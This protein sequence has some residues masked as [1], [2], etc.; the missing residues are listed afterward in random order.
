M[1]KDHLIAL[2]S[3]C[4]DDY[5]TVSDIPKQGEKSL[6]RFIENKVGGMIGNAAAVYAAYGHPT[7]MYDFM[8]FD[9]SNQ[10]L[11]EDLKQ[12][13]VNTDKIAFDATYP[14]SKCLIMLKGGERI[15]FVMDHTHVVHRLSV[16]QFEF[17]HEASYLYTTLSDFI[18]VENYATVFTQAKQHGLQIIF[19]VERASVQPIADLSSLLDFADILFINEQADDL[20]RE[21]LGDYIQT[22][23]Q[24]ALI[25]LTQAER[26]SMIYN[27]H[28]SL[29][30]EAYPVV[31]VDTTGAGDTYNVS[32]LHGLVSG[33]SLETCGRF[34]SAAASRSILRLGARSG[35]CSEAEV[36]AFMQTFSNSK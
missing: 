27:A 11:I 7:S 36:L 9:P 24:K 22:Y 12:A 23:R 14:S 15:I 6:A 33:W 25:V 34:A 19:D 16:A 30:I 3:N 13:Q 29:K 35:V 17:L 20:L 31:P 1:P 10:R 4:M 26:G 8:N 21:R 2:G 32:F 5:Y 18:Q 28:Q